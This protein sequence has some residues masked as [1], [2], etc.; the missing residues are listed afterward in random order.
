MASID[1]RGTGYRVRWRDPDG[2]A[3]SRACPIRESAKRLQR[4]VEACVAE[5]RRWT[6]R[7]VR[8]RATLGD[9]LEAYTRECVRVLKPDTAERYARNLDLFERY[10]G[11]RFGRTEHLHPGVLTRQLLAD[12]YDDLASG[13]L[14][15]R[16]RTLATRRKIVE[17]VQ[18]AWAWGYDDDTLGD[19]MPRPRKLRM[20]REEGRLTVAPTWDEMDRCIHHCRGWQKALTTVLRFTGL[21]VQQAMSLHWSDFDLHAGVLSIR[22]ELGK[23]RQERRGRVIPVSGHL[24]QELSGW[25]RHDHW[26]IHSA[27]SQGGSRERMARARDIGRAWARAGVREPAWKQPHHAFRKGFT[28]EMKRAGADTDAVEYLVGH[29]LGLRGV[30]TDPDALPL[31]QAVAKIPGLREPG[32]VIAL[33]RGA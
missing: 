16:P 17:V 3:R 10:L 29:S 15:G 23:S 5:G 11:K 27:R 25:P 4:E 1:K 21:R 12:F 31:R 24:V 30:Y 28:S 13:G 19:D 2:K 20:V 26:V 32:K 33:D 9:I 18:L 8:P 14:H 7:D 22:G 6:P